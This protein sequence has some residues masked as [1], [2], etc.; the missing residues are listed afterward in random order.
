MLIY[1]DSVIVIYF[2]ERLPVFQSRAQARLTTLRAAGDQIAVSELTRLECRVKPIRTGNAAVLADFDS[3]FA[4]PDLVHVPLSPAVYERATFIRA[5]Y[6]F[7]LGDALHL[8]A[9]GEGGCNLFLTNDRRLSAFPD[10]TVEVL[11]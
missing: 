11:P 4:A 2:V 8:A 3:F 10:I 1:L 9:A 5:R 7:R 6:N